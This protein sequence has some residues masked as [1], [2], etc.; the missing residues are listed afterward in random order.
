VSQGTSRTKK[1]QDEGLSTKE[2]GAVRGIEVKKGWIGG[3]GTDKEYYTSWSQMIAAEGNKFQKAMQKSIP[4]PTSNEWG[5]GNNNI[6]D[7]RRDEV[8]AQGQEGIRGESLGTL[9]RSTARN[10]TDLI[11]FRGA[12]GGGGENE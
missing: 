7:R 10:W 3:T 5:S 8:S 1:E 2:V 4:D 11:P 9:R 12:G 6:Q